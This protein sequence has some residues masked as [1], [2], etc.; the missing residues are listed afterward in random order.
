MDPLVTYFEAREYLFLIF[1][2]DGPSV[3]FQRNKPLLLTQLFISWL[4]SGSGRRR[5]S[6]NFV[7]VHL[8]SWTEVR[9][10]GFCGRAVLSKLHRSNRNDQVRLLDRHSIPI[11]SLRAFRVLLS[12]RI[13]RHRLSYSGRKSRGGLQPHVSRRRASLPSL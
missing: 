12:R 6:G 3:V 5:L 10:R 1:I 7:L 4:G 8:N 13:G 2:E 9:R 11:G